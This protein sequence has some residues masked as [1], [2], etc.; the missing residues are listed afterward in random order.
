[1]LE[2]RQ[3]NKVTDTAF[4]QLLKLLHSTSPQPNIIPPS[5]HLVRRILGCAE[6][7]QLEWHV[8]TC[9]NHAWLPLDPQ[10][11]AV[12]PADAAAPPA[13]GELAC[14]HCDA[15]RFQ[16]GP[17]GR[18]VVPKQVRAL[19]SG[20]LRLRCRGVQHPVV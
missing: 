2:W 13:A 19:A 7:W 4:G 3:A 10:H 5:L 15:S 20:P 6:L 16:V 18:G 11:W 8:C 12:P 1:M 17:R 9:H 14:P